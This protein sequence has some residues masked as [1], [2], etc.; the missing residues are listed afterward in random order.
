MFL[1]FYST[2]NVFPLSNANKLFAESARDCRIFTTQC[3]PVRWSFFRSDGMVNVFFQGTIGINGFSMV[4]PA[5]N[6]HHLMFFD[7]STIDFNGFLMVFR[8][9][10][11]K[12]NDG[13]QTPKLQKVCKFNSRQ[14]VFSQHRREIHC[15]QR[16]LLVKCILIN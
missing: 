2:T 15:S 3:R 7:Q 10:R 1:Q 4:L 9:F 14:N 16:K 12:V 6:Y 11:T 8:F 5:L 13:L